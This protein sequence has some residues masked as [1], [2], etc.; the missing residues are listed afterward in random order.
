MI[1]LPTQTSTQIAFRHVSR[2]NTSHCSQ[3]VYFDTNNNNNNEKKDKNLFSLL[4]D[5]DGE[6]FHL[7]Q[8][9]LEVVA[10]VT[11]SVRFRCSFRQCGISCWKSFMRLNENG[12]F[13]FCLMF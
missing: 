4:N 1:I 3:I 6:E 12:Y 7:H 5:C 8:I 10:S 11:G 13:L 9:N 2:F